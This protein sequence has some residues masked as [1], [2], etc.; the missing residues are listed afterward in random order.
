MLTTEFSRDPDVGKRFRRE[1]ESAT[2]LRLE[3]DSRLVVH[4]WRPMDVIVSEL[5]QGRPTLGW[6]VD[7]PLSP[8]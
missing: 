4:A 7:A 5:L 6:L 8:L 2:L 3:M 1:A